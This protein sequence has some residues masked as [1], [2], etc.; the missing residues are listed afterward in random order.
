MA[1]NSYSLPQKNT[2]HTYDRYL[3][4]LT[5]TLERIFDLYLFFQG[6]W[7]LHLMKLDY[8]YKVSVI[9][10]AE[11]KNSLL[12]VPFC[13][14]ISLLLEHFWWQINFDIFVF[15]WCFWKERSLLIIYIY[16]KTCIRNKSE[17]SSTIFWLLPN[18]VFL[19]LVWL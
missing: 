3:S 13:Q 8:Q 6:I 14:C 12:P 19:N 15:N 10:I 2:E 18:L 5:L 7:S 11:L 16:K 17:S 4:N 1:K 9:R